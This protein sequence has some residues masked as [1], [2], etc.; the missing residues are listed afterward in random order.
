MLGMSL[1]ARDPLADSEDA[2]TANRA[3]A[4]V[5]TVGAATACSST[6]RAF[7][8]KANGRKH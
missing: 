4:M 3:V 5:A 2:D 1:S 6:E 7:A 8:Y